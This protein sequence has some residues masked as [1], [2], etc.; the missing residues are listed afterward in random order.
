MKSLLAVLLV[1]SI[2]ACAATGELPR[3][4][5]DPSLPDHPANPQISSELPVVGTVLGESGCAPPGQSDP[6][7]STIKDQDASAPAAGHAGHEPSPAAGKNA[8]VYVCPMHP[9]VTASTPGD[10]PKCGMHLVESEKP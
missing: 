3:G 2:A 10:C 8:A 5:D 4:S 9:E 6:F 1:V 7:R